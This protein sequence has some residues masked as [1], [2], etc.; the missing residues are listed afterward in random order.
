[1]NLQDYESAISGQSKKPDAKNFS[2]VG[3]QYLENLFDKDNPALKNF[4]PEDVAEYFKRIIEVV[5]ENMNGSPLDLTTNTENVVGNQL[6]E[7]IMYVT[8]HTFPKVVRDVQI[9]LVKE[10]Q[11]QGYFSI[12]I[13]LNPPREKYGQYVFTRLKAC[14]AKQGHTF[15]SGGVL[16]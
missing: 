12:A 1:M 10:G 16:R 7:D 14:I 11:Q 2:F 13:C 8:E 9:S 5:S 15:V 3:I 4:K 6:W